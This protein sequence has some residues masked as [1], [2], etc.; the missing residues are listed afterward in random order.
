MIRLAALFNPKA[1]LFLAGR[2]RIFQSIQ[3]A[4]DGER[5]PLIWMHCAS[6]GEFEQG[7]PVIEALKRKHPE[8]AIFLTFFSPSGYETKKNDPLADYVF[9]LPFDSHQNARRLIRLLQPALALF[10]KYEFWFHYLKALYHNHVP[11]ILFSAYIQR[12]QPFFKWYGGIYRKMLGFYKQIFV[13]DRESLISL[14]EL[15]IGS[16]QIA[17]DTRF[18]RAGKVLA[19]PRSFPNVVAFKGN[20]KLIIAGSSWPEDERLLK[21]A[22]TRLPDFKLLIVPHETDIKNCSRIRDLFAPD[23][24]FW[25]VEKELLSSKKVAIV[26]GVGQLAFLYRYADIVWIGGG[27]GRGIHNIIEPAVYGVPVFFGPAYQRFREARELLSENAVQTLDT[28]D[29]FVGATQ[30]AAEL[31]NMSAKA[32]KYVQLQLGATDKII[33]YLEAK[34]L[35][36]TS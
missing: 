1:R 21:A 27:F 12:N 24:C 34:C 7:R 2:R 29:A 22:L 10:V 14:S 17:G 15:G 31:R 35:S 20:K 19:D 9:Y 36:S 32:K 18:D 25:D 5:R 28:A 8:Y 23:A 26:N 13:Q 30:D 6:L 11:V 16:V 3:N 4:L 33:H